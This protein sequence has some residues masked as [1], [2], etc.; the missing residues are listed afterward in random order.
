MQPILPI[1]PMKLIVIDLLLI[2]LSFLHA[3]AAFSKDVVSEPL[4]NIASSPNPVGSGARAIGMGGAFIAVADDATAASW[5]PAGLTQLRKPEFSVVYSY[6]RRSEDIGSST[7]PEATGN[8][9]VA[10][11][12]LN[13]LS[14]AYPFTICQRNMIVSLNYQ[15]LYEFNRD[16]SVNYKSI[17]YNPSSS[18][19]PFTKDLSK[20]DFKQQGALR[21]LSPAYAIQITPRVSLGI[22]LNF[23]TDKLFWSN[24]WESTTTSNSLTFLGQQDYSSSKTRIH[25]RY[26]DFS[27]FNMN[28]GFLWNINRILTL[29]AVLKTPF[30]ANIK[31]QRTDEYFSIRYPQGIISNDV[32]KLRE[33]VDLKMP[34]SFGVGIACRF[35]DAFTMD[36]D[37][38]WTDWSKFILEDGQ[39]QRLSLITGSLARDSHVKDTT[40]VRLGA[41]YLFI[42]T[43][44]IIPVRGGLFYDPEPAEG[45]PEDF[46]GF[47]LGSGISIK[48]VIFDCA[49]QYRHGNN[50]GKQSL[51]GIPGIEADVTQHLFLAS[52]IYHF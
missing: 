14:V 19:A 7:H 1:K 11:D 33:D 25:E 44:T 16:F 17:S 52:M 45:H 24:G 41:E 42:L 2:F 50:V 9:S 8:Y 47:S 20:M 29:G 30:T 51:T 32:S 49:Y 34:V 37:V 21:T 31:H 26:S 27:G 28:L 3:G 36:F 15:L 6:F 10:S 40:Q 12:D 39:G 38:Y 22:T 46:W 5:N 35:S 48:N 43:N 4:S 18:G 23:W 13:Y